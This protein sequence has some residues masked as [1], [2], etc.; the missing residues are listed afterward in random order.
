MHQN[1]LIPV[2]ALSHLSVLRQS[3]AC[4]IRLSCVSD[5]IAGKNHTTLYLRHDDVHRLAQYVLRTVLSL[6]E[7]ASS[8]DH[9]SMTLRVAQ[10]SDFLSQK[11]LESIFFLKPNTNTYQ[12]FLNDKPSCLES[13]DRSRLLVKIS[14]ESP[15]IQLIA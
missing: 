1:A 12:F 3:C 11:S 4:L 15:A 5:F 9:E 6:S 10:F 14:T 2:L 7:N 13:S 8:E